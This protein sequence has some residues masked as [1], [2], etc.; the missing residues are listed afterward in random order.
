MR[1]LVDLPE[2]DIRALD[3]LG[4]RRRVSRAKIIREAVSRFLSAS[5]DGSA[6]SAFGL[7]RD[8]KVDGLD[9][10]R[11]ARSEW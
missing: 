8:S 11:Q 6:D 10:Q 7:W 3:A 5:A 9:Y 1:T 2:A 4:E